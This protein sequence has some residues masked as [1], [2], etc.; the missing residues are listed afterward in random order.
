MLIVDQLEEAFDPA[1]LTAARALVAELC[2]ARDRGVEVAVALRA[3]FFDRALEVDPLPE[4]LAQGPVLVGP[5]TADELRRVIVEP[6][7][8]LGI[9][10]EDALVDVLVTE[11][12]AGAAAGKGLDAG[13]L[14]LVSHALYVTWAASP[15][16][17]L[18]LAH[19][20]E[21]GGLS[22]AIAKTAEDV[23]ASLTPEQQQVARRTMLRLVHVRDG[24]PDT[25]RPADSREFTSVEASDVLAA[26]IDSRLVTSDRGRV[27]LAHEV[28]ITA[29]PRLRGW[30]EEDRQ[31]LHVRGRLT[32]V[33]RPLAHRPARPRP[34][35]PRVGARRGREPARGAGPSLH[36]HRVR[37]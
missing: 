35:V 8:A 18:T 31:A 1:D 37:E 19:Y 21:A 6:A 22:G 28:L 15:G 10:V 25:R 23:Y 30:L 16:H 17:R 13:A 29:W 7:R 11:A 12:G 26:C 14:P 36:A 32:E 24:A 3:D 33:G 27:Q 5:L 34:P 2:D 20:R 4:W 9:E